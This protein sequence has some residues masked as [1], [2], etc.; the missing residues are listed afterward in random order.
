MLR[1]SSSHFDPEQ[2]LATASRRLTIVP[3]LFIFPQ[4]N[5]DAHPALSL[6]PASHPFGRSGRNLPPLESMLAIKY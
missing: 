3:L 1:L 2:T 5:F 4:I 6:L